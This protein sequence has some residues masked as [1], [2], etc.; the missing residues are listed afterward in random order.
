MV[1]V[2]EGKQLK[3]VAG[4]G[5]GGGGGGGENTKNVVV[6]VNVKEYTWVVVV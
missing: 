4:G 2:V 6:V 3:C 1:V 5:G